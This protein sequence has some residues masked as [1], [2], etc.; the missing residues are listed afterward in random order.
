MR[1]LF[2]KCAICEMRAAI[3]PSVRRCRQLCA[4]MPLAPRSPLCGA[5]VGSPLGAPRRTALCCL[6]LLIY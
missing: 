2:I 4:K 5:P 3:C 6:R 1:Q